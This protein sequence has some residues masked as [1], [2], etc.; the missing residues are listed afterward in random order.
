MKAKDMVDIELGEFL[1][2][3]FFLTSHKVS[4]LSELVNEDTNIIV[5]PARLR[6]LDNKGEGHR[7]PRLFLEQVTVVA[8]LRL[9][10]TSLI[11]LTRYTGKNK[12]GDVPC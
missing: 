5:T 11:S 12:L 2:R 8:V 9:V 1:C 10:A 6:K 7:M 3:H 4:H